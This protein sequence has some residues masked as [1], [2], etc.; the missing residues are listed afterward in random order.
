LPASSQAFPPY[1]GCGRRDAGE[2]PGGDVP[3]II[4]ARV[5]GVK[6]KDE[7]AGGVFLDPDVLNYIPKRRD[8]A[9]EGVERGH[10]LP[11]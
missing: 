8:H 10:P 7:D 11:G 6:G 5:G 2:S 3:F 4:S 9:A 1:G